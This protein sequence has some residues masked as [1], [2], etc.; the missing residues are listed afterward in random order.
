LLET[1]SLE[2]S[3][4]EEFRRDGCLWVKGA[5]GP[6][7]VARLELWADE[8][9]AR[10]EQPGRHWVYHEKSV[11]DGRDLVQR[12]EYI[13]PFHEGFSELEHALRQSAA[14]LLGEPAE[15]FKEKINYKQQ[16]GDGFKPHQDSQAGWERYAS[17][18]L[19]V[20]V[21]IDACTAENGCLEI[22][23]GHQRPGLG[24]TWEPLSEQELAGIAFEPIPA[25]PGDMVF[26][27]SYAPHRSFPNRS[28]RAR[29][30]YFATYNR[31]SEGRHLEAYYADKRKSFP[32]DVERDPTRTYVFR[33]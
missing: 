31:R 20:A 4:V 13:S 12:I 17:Y 2:A 7:S 18:F 8:L 29:R 10:P 24:R 21:A 1:P 15:L 25:A 9:L 16:G 30:V 19:T 11:R 3:Q 26:L 33:V 14:Q 22:A 6:A 5:F 32:P 27:D 28:D 23:R